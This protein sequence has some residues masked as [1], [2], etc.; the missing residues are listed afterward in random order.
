MFHLFHFAVLILGQHLVLLKL[1]KLDTLKTP[2]SPQSAVAHVAQ[3]SPTLSDLAHQLDQVRWFLP[4]E[5]GA[6]KGR[7]KVPIWRQKFSPKQSLLTT[8][9]SVGHWALSWRNKTER[10]MTWRIM[11]RTF[12]FA[13]QGKQTY[14]DIVCQQKGDGGQDI[15]QLCFNNKDRWGENITIKTKTTAA[16]L[17]GF[18]RGPKNIEIETTT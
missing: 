15:A 14:K 6:G 4:K 18:H 9:G 1:S 5:G 16:F 12:F 13:N 3:G 11:L 7:H 17:K 10:S 8:C 2:N